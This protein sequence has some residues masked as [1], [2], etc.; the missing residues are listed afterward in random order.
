MNPAR[1]RPNHC[2]AGVSPASPA[3]CL[4]SSAAGTAAPQWRPSR[5]RGFT[6][7]EML[8]VIVIIS[9]LIGLL[10]VAVAPAITKGKVATVRAEIDQLHNAVERYKMEFGAYPPS[11]G[12]LGSTSAAPGFETAVQ[13]EARIL[14]HIRKAFPRYVVADFTALA[15]AIQAGTS[16]DLTD[17]SDGLGISDL[18]SAEVIVFFLGGLPI[19]RPGPGGT[20]TW[21]LSGFCA[22]PQAPFLHVDDPQGQQ[23][24]IKLF[25]FDTRRLVDRDGDGWPE[26]I[27]PGTTTVAE[28]PPYV[29]FDS[30]SYGLFPHYPGNEPGPFVPE[31]LSPFELIGD[32]GLAFPYVTSWEVAPHTD[33]TNS[34]AWNLRWVN[35]STFQIISAGQ[36][37]KY[38]SDDLSTDELRARIRARQFPDGGYYTDADND[39][40]TNFTDTTLEAAKP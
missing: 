1:P 9:I 11:P 32:W 23:R 18:D 17:P 29:Y 33:P 5:P 34:Q 35:P 28:M 30:T 19:R 4:E 38:G 12:T 2:G 8:M 10:I 13:R 22:N 15:T 16:R 37:G 39:N 40:V 25:E 7:V 21:E 31:P 27:P 24:T 14:R 6:L 3:A 26:Y 36:D 20:E